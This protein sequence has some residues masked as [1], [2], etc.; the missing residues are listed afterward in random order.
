MTTLMGARLQFL[1]DITSDEEGDEGAD[2]GVVEPGCHP[3]QALVHLT[4]VEPVSVLLA[5]LVSHVLQVRVDLGLTWLD[6]KHARTGHAFNV[7][8]LNAVRAASTSA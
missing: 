2:C 1:A 3:P 5:D 6:I 8:P 4:W 7:A